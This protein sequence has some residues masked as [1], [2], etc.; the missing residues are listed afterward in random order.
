[1]EDTYLAEVKIT[2]N[3]ALF[4]VFDGHGGKLS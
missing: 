4:G 3:I 1:M 2:E